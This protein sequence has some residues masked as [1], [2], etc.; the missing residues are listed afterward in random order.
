VLLKNLTEATLIKRYK[1]F[2]ADVR[3]PDGEEITVHCPN[4]GSM[5]GINQ[6]GQK[7]LLAKSA[8]LKRKL[9]WTLQFVETDSSAVL[10]ESALANKLFL[11]A[12]DGGLL[13]PLAAFSHARAEHSYK[14][15]RFDFLLSDYPLASPSKAGS[16]AAQPA[17]PEGIDPRHCLVEVKSTTYIEGDVALFPDAQT[18]RGRKHLRTLA[19]AVAEGL[20]ALQFY[21]VARSDAGLFRPADLIDSAYGQVLRGAHS[22][23]VKVLAYALGFKRHSVGDC[24][25]DLE[26]CLE[27]AIE[28]DLTV[29]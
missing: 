17:L 6:P 13:E 3:M 8:N 9:P 29:I 25:V 21:V 26:V 7:V 12:F 4:P 18:E 23:G 24:L 15:S 14:D 2:L 20:Q 5:L 10:V 22:R 19:E 28:I 1:R 11:E 27:K 16:G